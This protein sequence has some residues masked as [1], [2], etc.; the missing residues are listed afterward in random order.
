MLDAGTCNGNTE[1]IQFTMARWHQTQ[2]WVCYPKPPRREKTELKG[3]LSYQ[4][5]M[6]ATVTAKNDAAVR[7]SVVVTEENAW[8]SKC[9]SVGVLLKQCLLKVCEKGVTLSVCRGVNSWCNLITIGHIYI[10]LHLQPKCWCGPWLPPSSH[11]FVPPPPLLLLLLLRLLLLLLFLPV[12]F[13]GLLQTTVQDENSVILQQGL[14]TNNA[15][16]LMLNN[17]STRRH[18]AYSYK[19]QKSFVFMYSAINHCVRKKWSHPKG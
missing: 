17:D 11:V 8:P 19:T 18:Y 9:S 14:L 10:V 4:Q 5:H 1:G 2:S 15:N 16:M 13:I 7:C 3:S 6:L 12:Y